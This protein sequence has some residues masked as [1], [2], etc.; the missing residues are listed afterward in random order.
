MTVFILGCGTGGHPPGAMRRTPS[1]D[2]IFFF[3]GKKMR[4]PFPERYSFLSP[5]PKTQKSLPKTA[6]EFNTDL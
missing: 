1:E 2:L 5:R 4:F 3:S 6:A